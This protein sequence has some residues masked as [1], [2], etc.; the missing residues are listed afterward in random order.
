MK[1]LNEL[2]SCL[3]KIDTRKY[4]DLIIDK[5]ISRETIFILNEM[6]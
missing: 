4:H 6:K 3:E 2:E 1:Y 5:V